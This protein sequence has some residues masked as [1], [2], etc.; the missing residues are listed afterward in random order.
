MTRLEQAIAVAQEH[1]A[2]RQRSRCG[3]PAQPSY[4]PCLR[5]LVQEVGCDMRTCG[6]CGK[7]VAIAILAAKWMEISG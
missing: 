5:E 4:R 3:N 2:W 1:I 7:A 6:R